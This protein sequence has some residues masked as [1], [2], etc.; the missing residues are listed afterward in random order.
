[1]NGGFERNSCRCKRC[2][3][4]PLRLRRRPDSVAG[5]SSSRAIVIGRNSYFKRPSLGSGWVVLVSST[6][7]SYPRQRVP[8]AAGK[9]V[10][11]F[12]WA[13]RNRLY[14]RN[15]S[16]QVRANG[17]T[18]KN[19]FLKNDSICMERIEFIV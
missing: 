19:I 14:Y 1:V 9:Y 18:I 17:V 8:M 12:D 4:G 16:F 13:P 6:Y 7:K 3:F 11:S 5:W 2:R 15:P 10:L